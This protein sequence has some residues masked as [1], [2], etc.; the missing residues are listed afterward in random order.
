MRAILRDITLY[1]ISAAAPAC[2]YAQ[3]GAINNVGQNPPPIPAIQTGALIGLQG[4]TLLRIELVND[5]PNASEDQYHLDEQRLLGKLSQKQGLPIE[6]SKLRDDLRA[7]FASGKFAQIAVE[8]R[9]EGNGVVL[10]Y[11]TLPRY[12]VGV[13]YITGAPPHVNAARLIDITKLQ[14]G[15]AFTQQKLDVALTRIKQTLAENGWYQATITPELS[16]NADTQQE[17]VTFHIHKGEEARIGKVD[18]TGNGGTS[19]DELHEIS[20]MHP[21][22]RVTGT[23]LDRA[24]TKLR[25]KLQKQGRLEA[26]VNVTRQQYDPATNHVN[27]TLNLERGPIV[28]V[29]LEGAKLRKSKLKKFIPVY[30]ENAVDDDLL[31]EGR[32]N[33]RDYFQTQGYFDATVNFTQKGQ[34]NGHNEILYSVDKGERHKLLRVEMVGNKYFHAEELRDLMSVQPADILLRRGSFSQSGLTHD[35]NA[36]QNLY[37]ANGFANVKVTPEVVDDFGGKVGDLV[38]RYHVDE[39]TQVRIANLNVTGVTLASPQEVRNLLADASAGQPYSP[40]N[41]ASDRDSVL[42]YYYNRGFPQAQFESTSKPVSGD[43]GRVDLTIKIIE[44][45]QIFVDRTLLYGLHHTHP[46]IVNREIEIKQGAPLDQNAMLA[47]QRNLYDLSIFNEVDEA[48][49]NPNGVT[50][51]KNVILSMDEAR[52]YTFN[53]GLGFEAQT[54][55]VNSSGCATRNPNGTINTK[56]NPNGNFGFSPR[57]SFDVSRINLRGTDQSLTFKGHYGRLQKRAL[58]SYDVPRLFNH[59]SLTFTAT[60][61]YDNTQDVLTFTAKRLEGSGQVKQQVTKATTFLYRYSYRRVTV[62]NV[63]VGFR[64]D[65][66]PTLSLPV[67]V[68]MPGF[69]FV[70]DTR[71]DPLDSKKGT[72]NTADLALSSTAFGSRCT[73]SLIAG[74]D[75]DTPNGCPDP[76]FSRI[77][78]QNSSYFAFGKNKRKWVFARTVRVG[79]ETPFGKL[80]GLVPLAERFYAGG[81]N[82]HRGFAINQAGPR[83]SATGFPIGGNG[84]F[85]NSLELRTPPIVLPL[86]GD[87]LSAVIF[88]DMG[89]T[90]DTTG[91]MFRSL[92]RLSQPEQQSCKANPNSPCNF[93]YN[94]QAIG[95]GLRYRTPIGPIRVDLGYDLNPP[96]F[97]R[98][99]LDPSDPA[100]IRT[101]FQTTHTGRLNVFFSIGQTF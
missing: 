31:N 21:G 42:N 39:G 95:A 62:Q 87:N 8:S 75:P 14:L 78:I 97:H 73:S 30:E 50:A 2:V 4:L 41:I 43:P 45:D 98:T 13:V 71:D 94:S 7:L 48:V 82:S 20:K 36:I 90:Y 19:K 65:Q 15:E 92:F 91:H 96:L 89:N 28:D 17:Q 56:C 81:S 68:G 83:D 77:S 88:H 25:K 51:Y 49:Q 53:Y 18:I 57:V 27:Y 33:L 64:I 69:T 52:R 59:P 35:V 58:L 38:V 54:G 1:M 40:A 99:V 29:K 32:R 66:F 70:R 93:N 67:N 74:Q 46:S 22:D 6:T 80:G 72:Y 60:T 61:F 3:Q 23:T 76:S 100:G 85:I 47:T 101:L 11:H 26:Q 55:Q 16:P 12:F 79:S 34:G 24:L 63:N 84:E 9:H 44:G 5:S 37:K 10:T 86:A